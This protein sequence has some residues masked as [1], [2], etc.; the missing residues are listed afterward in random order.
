MPHHETAICRGDKQSVVDVFKF[1]CYLFGEDGA[2][3]E[4]E[5][6]IEP[7]CHCGYCGDESYSAC[8]CFRHRCQSADTFFN[9]RSCC[10]GGAGDEHEGHLHGE[11]EEVPHAAAPVAYHFDYALV[12]DRYGDR[13]GDKSED[14]SKDEGLRQI[15]LHEIDTTVYYFVKKLHSLTNFTVLVRPSAFVIFRK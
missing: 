4:T 12:A 1:F 3:D 8:W 13:D 10:E 7:T 6:P 11:S 2:D 5:A 14:Y 15:F 9:K